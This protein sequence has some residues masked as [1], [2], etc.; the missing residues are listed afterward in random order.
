MVDTQH[1][2]MPLGRLGMPS[3]NYQHSQTETQNRQSERLA[4]LLVR[5]PYSPYLRPQLYRNENQ[6]WVARS[7]AKMRKFR[8][9]ISNLRKLDRRYF[10]FSFVKIRR[11]FGKA[12]DA[13]RGKRP[14]E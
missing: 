8:R 6:I 11:G 14:A 2:P 12:E 3:S 10:D 9:R 4:A 5:L 7:R 1:Q 13:D